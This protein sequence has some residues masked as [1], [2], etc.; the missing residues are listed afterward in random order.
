MKILSWNV[1]GIGR[2]E[3]RRQIKKSLAERKVDIVLLQETKKAVVDSTLV[4]SMWPGEQFDFMAVDVIGQAGGLLC[5]WNPEVFFLKDCCSTQNFILLSGTLFSSFDCVI[6]NVYG[7]NEVAKRK[8]TWDVLVRLKSNFLGP[9]C[10]GG[11]FNEIKNISERIGCSRR[12]RGMR[13]FNNMIAQLELIDIPMLG[14]KFTWCNSQVREKW[15]RIDRF[16]LNYEWV[17]NFSFKLWGLPRFL[18]DHCP[19]ILMED[20]RDWGPKPFRFLNAWLLHPKFLSCVQ[21]S[22]SESAVDGWAGFKCL[23]KFKA[24]K[25]VLKQWNVA[26]LVRLN[27]N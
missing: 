21:Q 17:Q 5:I 13:D 1:R 27:Q 11:D 18:S 26:V 8:E 9:C 24:L 20:D 22:W 2:P 14:K 16:L 3:K 23:M 12:D 15:S 7:S 19:I 10:M 6:I 4:R 25:Q